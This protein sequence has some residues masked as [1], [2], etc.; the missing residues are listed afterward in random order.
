MSVKERYPASSIATATLTLAAA[1]TLPL[2]LASPAFASD[3]K[4]KTITVRLRDDGPYSIQFHCSAREYT[5]KPGETI[6][7]KLP[8][9]DALTTTNSTP[10]YPSGTKIVSAYPYLNDATIILH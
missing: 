4:R 7:L 1:V 8:V 3:A 5:I 9:G 10:K 6:S 2:A